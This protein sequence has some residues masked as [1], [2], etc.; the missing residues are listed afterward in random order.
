MRPKEP[1][2]LTSDA[3]IAVAVSGGSD[4]MAVLHAM[5]GQR[6]NNGPHNLEA[7]TV[8]HGLR[9]GSVDEAARVAA[10]C[11]EL[12]IKH[13]TLTW[14]T[15]DGA[16][17]LQ[18]AA[19]R[20]RYKLMADWARKTGID[21]IVLGHTKDDLAETFLMQV[22]RKAGLDGLTS[23]RDAVEIHGVWFHRP[24]LGARRSELQAQLRQA[25]V[26]WIDDPSNDDD[27]F[28][29]DHGPNI[30]VVISELDFLLNHVV[31]HF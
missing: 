3:E 9:D 24:F 31:D 26:A 29:R 17:N 16:G 12:G 27:V 1:P 7:V 2:K 22:A 25:G 20:A 21:G 14:G 19:R 8:D 18:D 4:S 10:F 5:A 23:L 6:E 28:A 13:T 30:G 11:A 15:W